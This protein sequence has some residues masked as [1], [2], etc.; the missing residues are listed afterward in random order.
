VAVPE[1]KVYDI[2][3][4]EQVT[5]PTRSMEMAFQS[6]LG[7]LRSEI[8]RM[9]SRAQCVE[10]QIAK[11]RSESDRLLLPASDRSDAKV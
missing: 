4:P 5:R 7:A 2:A 6:Q 3:T 1:T 10:Q 9:Q 8:G 11:Y